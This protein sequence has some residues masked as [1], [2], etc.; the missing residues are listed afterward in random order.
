MNRSIYPPPPSPPKLILSII[1]WFLALDCLPAKSKTKL[2]LCY[3][4][5]REVFEMPALMRIN[6]AEDVMRSDCRQTQILCSDPSLAPCRTPHI[7]GVWLT[8]RVCLKM[9]NQN[10]NSTMEICCLQAV[11][12]LSLNQPARATATTGSGNCELALQP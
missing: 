6:P 7:F 9:S 3:A 12:A 10:H 2:K 1:R 5:F 4:S 11:P 8:C